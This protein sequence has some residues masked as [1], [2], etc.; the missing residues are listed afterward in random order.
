M[1]KFKANTVYVATQITTRKRIEILSIDLSVEVVYFLVKGKVH[2]DSLRCFK[3][4]K[5]LRPISEKEKKFL[6]AFA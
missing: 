6:M 4:F 3:N 5:Q 2:Q 1:M